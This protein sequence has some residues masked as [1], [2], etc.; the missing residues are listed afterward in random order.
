M[1]CLYFHLM[2][3]TRALGGN[4]S[5]SPVWH[6]AKKLRC[7]HRAAHTGGKVLACAQAAP[8]GLSPTFFCEGF[9]IA[10]M[11]RELRR[12]LKWLWLGAWDCTGHGDGIWGHRELACTA[13]WPAGR[14]CT[15]VMASVEMPDMEREVAS[16]ILLPNPPGAWWLCPPVPPRHRGDTEGCPEAP[17]A[18]QQTWSECKADRA[19]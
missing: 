12:Q 3:R 2:G 10:G 19:P 15:Q 4:L 5:V 18:T 14:N 6:H 7:P 13:K 1:A 8:V 17:C 11:A 16:L 9:W